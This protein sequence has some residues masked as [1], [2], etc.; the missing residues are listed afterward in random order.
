MKAHQEKKSCMDSINLLLPRVVYTDKDT[1]W[2]FHSLRLFCKCINHMVKWIWNKALDFINIVPVIVMVLLRNVLDP[3]CTYCF[4]EL[5]RVSN[6]GCITCQ[7]WLE[8]ELCLSLAT[9]TACVT[10]AGHLCHRPI[11]LP[12][13]D[14]AARKVHI[15]HS[16]FLQWSSPKWQSIPHGQGCAVQWWRR[17]GWGWYASHHCPAR[18]DPCPRDQGQR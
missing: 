5:P 7:E 12:T 16:A 9:H 11:S 3:V 13:A 2:Y 6:G 15:Q 4:V 1:H 18:H 10:I 8:L 17:A 14:G